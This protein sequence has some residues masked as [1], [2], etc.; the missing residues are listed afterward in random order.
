MPG[1]SIRNLFF[2]IV[3]CLVLLVIGVTRL[4][5]MPVGL[6]PSINLPEVVMATF[7]SG[8]PPQ[9]GGRSAPSQLES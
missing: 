4:A 6:F 5:R 7:Y 2:I 8:M 1:F 9:H 3:V